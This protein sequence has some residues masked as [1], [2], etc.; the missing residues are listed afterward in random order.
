M[1]PEGDQGKIKD[2]QIKLWQI[3]QQLS[4]QPKFF[5]DKDFYCTVYSNGKFLLLNK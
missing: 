3:D 1:Y 2:W 5:T 4:N